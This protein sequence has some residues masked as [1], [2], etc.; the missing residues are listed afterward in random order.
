MP[1]SLVAWKQP[2]PGSGNRHRKMDQALQECRARQ[3]GEVTV[4]VGRVG[5]SVPGVL[6]S[7]VAALCTCVSAASGH[8]Q[9]SGSLR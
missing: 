8:Q 3:G 1:W 6:V 2:V 5:R 4:L 7:I 9:T